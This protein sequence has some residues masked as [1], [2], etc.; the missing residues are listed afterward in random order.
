MTL[1]AAPQNQFPEFI[2]AYFES[3]RKACPKLIGLCGKWTFE[4]LI[5]G[6]SDFDTRL[7]F[8]DD[9]T[10]SDWAE[11]SLVVGRVH[12]ELAQ[13]RPE[14]RRI[15][16]HL[17]G[18]N[19][20]PAE[21][22]DP[23]LYLPEVHLWTLYRGDVDMAYD[24]HWSAADE[25]FHMKKF[26]TYFGP[27]QRGIDPAI[28]LGPYETK[29][30]LHSRYMHYFAPPVQAAVALITRRPVRGKL[31]ALEIA[32]HLFPH[33][34]TIGRVLDAV[35]AHYEIKGDYEEP[36][37]TNIEREL[38]F[39]LNSALQVLSESVDSIEINPQS[40]PEQLRQ[41]LS[42]TV[43][44]PSARLF[45]L[46]CFSRLMRGRLLFFAEHIPWFE[47]DWLIRNEHGRILRLFYAQPLELYGSAVCQERLTAE[48][49]LDRIEEDILPR[50]LA[51]EYKNFADLAS[52][53]I[54]PGKEKETARRVG[55]AFE[56]V[57]IALELL[58]QDLRRRVCQQDGRHPHGA[59]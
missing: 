2:D 43:V 18:I 54:E 41:R 53:S 12:T 7:I 14:W 15:L 5:P 58:M 31:K 25:Y 50:S 32:R 42:R 38:E 36:Q 23:F 40:A 6:L 33:P 52:E 16:E 46:V 59:F 3:S 28:N 44:A 4:D 17:P 47:T 48:E 19:L 21:L 10:A 39:Y 35:E 20:T 29:Y 57:Q 24:G 49:V 30:P 55:H 37:L 1:A 51:R 56:P 13:K 9:M 11:A 27:Y 22:H 26:A 8:Q 45:E 34:E